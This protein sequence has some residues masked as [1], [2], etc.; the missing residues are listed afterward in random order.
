MRT[1]KLKSYDY[2][3][4]LSA[5]E[6]DRMQKARNYS[7]S[8]NLEGISISKTE[9]QI[10]SFFIKKI[11]ARKVVEIGTLTGLSALYILN[12]IPQDGTLWTIEK[13][14]EHAELAQ[15]ILQTEISNG[16]CHLLIGDAKEKIFQLNSE[17]LFDA[18][19]IDGNK[20]AYL[21]YFNWAIDNVRPK[22]LIIV[23]NVFLS[24]SVWGE[25]NQKKFNEKQIASVNGV[26]LKS[27]NSKNLNSIIIPT[28][29]GMLICEKL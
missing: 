24:G 16:R 26:N 17:G 15:K 19:F 4:S 5:P 2:I 23:D 10:V 1:N 28:E 12:S 6:D 22:G 9:A 20:A 11:G 21:D 27:F 29:E 8:L 25:I 18:V 7:Q 14:T 13:S 3:E